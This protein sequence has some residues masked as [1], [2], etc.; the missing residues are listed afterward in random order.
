[1]GML[2]EAL[3][4]REPRRGWEGRSD[5]CEE[6]PESTLPLEVLRNLQRAWE[7]IGRITKAAATREDSVVIRDHCYF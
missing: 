4:F 5:A 6:I 7:S 1:M 3:G 2:L